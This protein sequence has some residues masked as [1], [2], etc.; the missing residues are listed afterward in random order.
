ME[1]NLKAFMKPELKEQETIEL[2]GVKAFTDSKGE[3]IPFILR[4]LT[5]SQLKE[6]RDNNTTTTVVKDKRTNRPMVGNN[7]RIVYDE[8]YDSEAAGR[9]IMVECFVQPDLKA[10]ELREFY[11]VQ[12]NTELPEKLFQGEDWDYANKCVLIACGLA[13]EETQDEIM[14]KVKN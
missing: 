11:G 1:I 5:R 14:K 8:Q 6:I 4:K 9:E 3:P 10:K 7:N 12:L 13:D 2:P